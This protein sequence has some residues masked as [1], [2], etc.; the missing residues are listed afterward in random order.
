MTYINSGNV[1]F[2]SGRSSEKGL[3][4]DLE[5]AIEKR[6]GRPVRRDGPQA[7]HYP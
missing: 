2:D 5:E 4:K 7:K 6:F 3:V 1:A